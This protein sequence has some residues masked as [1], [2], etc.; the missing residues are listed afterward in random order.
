MTPVFC[1]TPDDQQRLFDAIG[2]DEVPMEYKNMVL[3]IEGDQV[4]SFQHLADWDEPAITVNEYLST[5]STLQDEYWKGMG[6]VTWFTIGICFIIGGL[7][8]YNYLK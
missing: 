8:I 2:S 6:N 1:K 4:H 7:L 3:L 5:F